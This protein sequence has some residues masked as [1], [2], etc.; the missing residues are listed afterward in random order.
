[1]TA[2]TP[3]KR[4]IEEY[5]INNYTL[6]ELTPKYVERMAAYTVM[7]K[8]LFEEFKLDVISAECWTATPVMF[9]GFAPCTVYGLLNDMGYMVSCESDMHCNSRRR[10]ASVR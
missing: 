9:D 1:M 3:E 7:Y 5:I 10:K 2:T 4:E 8:K 6:D